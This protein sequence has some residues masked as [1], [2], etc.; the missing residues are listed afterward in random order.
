MASVQNIVELLFK[1][2]DQASGPSKAITASMDG[3]K[4]AA[5]AA[6]A[7]AVAVGGGA[8]YAAKK[9][10]ELGQKFEDTSLSIAGA[11]Q[12]YDLAPNIELAEKA[13]VKALGNIDR[14]AAKLPGTTEDYVEVFKQALPG[15]IAAGA[16]D[17]D[18][19][20]DFTSRYTAVATANMV[21][22]Q[23][24]GSDLSLMLT[25]LAG[26]QVAMFRKLAP[27]IG[28]TAE[29][30]NK[31]TREARMAA[32]DKSLAGYAGMMQR[33]G[34]TMGSKL[35][36]AEAHINKIAR[37]AGGPIFDAML[38]QLSKL[39]DYFTKNEKSVIA[40]GQG[41]ATTVVNAIKMVID[42]F[43]TVVSLA[44]NLLE[45]WV[46]FKIGV[47]ASEITTGLFAIAG[48]FTAI[49]VSATEAAAAEAAATAGLSALVGLAVG[50]ASFAGMKYF[51]GKAKRGLSAPAAAAEVAPLSSAALRQLG[52]IQF[53]EMDLAKSLYGANQSL[54]GFATLLPDFQ[55]EVLRKI[56]QGYPAGSTAF[57][58]AFESHVKELGFDIAEIIPEAKFGKTKIPGGPGK[59][60]IKF[61]NARFDIK[62]NFAEGF[63]PDR[64]A[65]AFVDQLGAATMYRTQSAFSGQPGTG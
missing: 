14:M 6:S 24:A 64:I 13:A 40:I 25:G 7:A 32:I 22:A 26:Q 43:E 8:L 46:S 18:K 2:S 55:Q 35:G 23:Q 31:M 58:E 41:L 27:L 44:K 1:V 11:I 48:A 36:E 53:Q 19:I 30:F 65:A 3:I 5:L 17:L 52:A 63:D 4:S 16:Q 20:A 15:A 28:K 34:D 49:T 9:A 50:A 57:R 62:Q 39:N 29:E 10:V 33:A 42:N 54:E 61:D 59:T 38:D 47:V 51:E 37:L 12:A 56:G 60:E 21:D 45:L